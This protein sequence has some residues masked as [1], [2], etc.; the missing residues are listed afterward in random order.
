LGASIL[1]DLR[2]WLSEDSILRIRP[3]SGVDPESIWVREAHI[4]VTS[5]VDPGK[6]AVKR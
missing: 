2:D 5:G 4:W 3:I 1:S 6:A